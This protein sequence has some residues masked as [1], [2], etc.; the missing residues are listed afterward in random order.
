MLGLFLKKKT[1][2]FPEIVKG[3]K[4]AVVLVQNVIFTQRCFLPPELKFWQKN[5]TFF[6]SE[7]KRKFAEE[8][9]CI[10]KKRF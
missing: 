5:Q 6:N 1:C 8:K 9:I 7:K 4:F 10:R 2:F 3:G